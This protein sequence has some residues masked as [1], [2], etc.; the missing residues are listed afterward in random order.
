MGTQIVG[1]GAQFS[2]PVNQLGPELGPEYNPFYFH[3]NRPDARFAPERFLKLVKEIEKDCTV[4][5][6]PIKERYGLWYR[7]PDRPNH[8]SGHW[9]LVFWCEWDGEYCLDNRILA[10]LWTRVRRG[11]GEE[12]FDALMRESAR[13]SEIADKDHDAELKA[14]GDEYWEYMKIKNTGQGNKFT[15]F[16]QGEAM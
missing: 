6:N 4:V 7:S 14:A 16:G 15:R 1:E 3:P 2:Q 9:K 10:K 5:W 12:Y 11:R 13:D 8:I